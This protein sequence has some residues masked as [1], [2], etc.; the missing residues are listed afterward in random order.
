MNI[1]SPPEESGASLSELRYQLSKMITHFGSLNSSIG[2]LRRE[3]I[4]APLNVGDGVVRK[5][6][7]GTIITPVAS[8]TRGGHDGTNELKTEIW[9]D[10]LRH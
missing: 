1:P 10:S 3:M 6:G 5:H 2:W 8:E 9:I 4:Q 7:K